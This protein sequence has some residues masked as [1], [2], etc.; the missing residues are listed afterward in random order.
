M[1]YF[2]NFK[3]FREYCRGSIC[4]SLLTKEEMREVFE[5]VKCVAVDSKRLREL[6]DKVHPSLRGKGLR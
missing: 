6:R 3:E 1:H 4:W 5:K 2:S